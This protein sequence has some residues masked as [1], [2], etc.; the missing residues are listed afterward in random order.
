MADPLLASIH[1]EPPT[2][3]VRRDDSLYSVPL[4]RTVHLDIVF[5]PAYD[6]YP[7]KRTGGEPLPVLYLNDGQDLPRLRMT[8]VLDSLYQKKA[9]RPFILVAIHAGDRIQEYGT[10][11]QADYMHRGSKAGLYTDF[12]L[13]ELLPYIKKHYRVSGDPAKS[14]FA[15]F[16]LGGLSA[17]D[18]VFHHPDRFSRA[19]VF[20]GSFWWR[21]KSSEEGYRDE[22]DRIMHDLVRKG[23]YTPSLKFWFET[24]TD[25][26]T[27]DRNNNGVIDS[28]DDTLD[29][30]SE[31][32]KK[33]YN[34]ERDIRYVEV[35]GGQHNQQTW[36]QIMPDF[37]KW[38]FP[39]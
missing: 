4:K 28:I 37:L 17:F 6:E 32:V 7:Q 34:R 16:S 8:D 21:S 36:S 1:A 25:D 14:V 22:T 39:E 29:L 35:Q 38:A 26:E 9:I 20:S 11:A 19:G 10:A 30:I 2:V 31:L 13:T 18:L 24:G 23:V 15:G 3:T 12:V 5:P 33:G 27:S